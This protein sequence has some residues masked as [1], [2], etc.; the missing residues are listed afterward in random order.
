MNSNKRM[1]VVLAGIFAALAIGMVVRFVALSQYGVSGSWMY[2]GLLPFGGIGL[3]VL[4]LRLGLLNLGERS[5]RSAAP[6]PYHLTVHSAPVGSVA[7]R[8]QHLESM[9]A[10]G[11][12][13]EAE[14]LA[15]RQQIVSSI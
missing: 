2:L 13:S 5:H 11:A 3:I 9:R 15:H 8:L 12:I 6:W 1:A 7:H 10:S 14:Y 4:V